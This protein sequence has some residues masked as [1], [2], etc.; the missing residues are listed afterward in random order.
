MK[1][2][3]KNAQR[4][5]ATV[6]AAAAIGTAGI[7]AAAPAGAVAPP[8]LRITGAVYCDRTEFVPTLVRTMTARNVGG[9]TMRNTTLQEINGQR[10]FSPALKPGETLNI[11]TKQRGCFP[12]SIAGYTISDIRENVFDNF[13]YWTN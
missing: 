11:T 2:T 4:A 7:V 9:V 1:N 6:L 5:A 13:G 8:E 3:R 12:S 10:R